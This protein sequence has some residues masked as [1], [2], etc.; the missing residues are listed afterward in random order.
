MF[1]VSTSGQRMYATLPF[2]LISNLF[3][4]IKFVVICVAVSE[5][6]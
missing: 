4:R 6:N 1:S 3:S 5:F 2:T